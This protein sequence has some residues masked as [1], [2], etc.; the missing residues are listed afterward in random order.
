[1]WHHNKNPMTQS[2]KMFIMHMIAEF[3]ENGYSVWKH[4]S[5]G[6]SFENWILVWRRRQKLKNIK[7]DL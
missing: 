4:S 5:I 2:R 7:I 1:M 6:K 3:K